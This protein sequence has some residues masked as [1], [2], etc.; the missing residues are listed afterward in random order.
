MEF[1]ALSLADD[2][3]SKLSSIKEPETEEQQDQMRVELIT[4]CHLLDMWELH[5]IH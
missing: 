2:G 4:V 3:Y 1:I 5:Y